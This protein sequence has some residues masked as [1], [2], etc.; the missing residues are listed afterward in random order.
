MKA[1]AE[2]LYAQMAAIYVERE[3]AALH[4]ELARMEGAPL[5][6]DT[7]KSQSAPPPQLGGG[8]D[9]KLRK[10]L[11]LL[12]YRVH[13]PRIVG[14]GLAAAACLALA[15]LLPQVFSPP[16][17]G[18]EAL[19]LAADS[20]PV[21]AAP[22]AA[23]YR[24]GEELAESFDL[25]GHA[26]AAPMAIMEEDFFGWDETE[27]GVFD[28][29][30][31][32]GGNW[33]EGDASGFAPFMG[34][35]DD[36]QMTGEALPDPV[37]G[38]A[39]GGEFP[40]IDPNWAESAGEIRPIHFTPPDGFYQVKGFYEDGFYV[41]R[42]AHERALH[43]YVNLIIRSPD[44]TIPVWAFEGPVDLGGQDVYYW[45]DP[46]GYGVSVTFEKNSLYYRV[47]SGFGLE[48]TLAFAETVIRG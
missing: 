16:Q 1:E 30:L 5:P 47:E 19:Q 18:S 3:G 45:I 46:R 31:G 10:G 48:T 22:F 39:F 37:D 25:E 23:Q 20:A 33:A 4:A 2:K 9:K 42:F 29:Q 43:S 12:K 27:S 26:G 41:Y 36:N 44:D 15:V 38:R 11:F 7:E 6:A 17:M 40:A 24:M 28:P 13:I 34:E 14:G 21:E 35:I 8:L 32:G